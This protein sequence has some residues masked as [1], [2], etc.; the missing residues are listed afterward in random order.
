MN[1]FD[2]EERCSQIETLL[3]YPHVGPLTRAAIAVNLGVSEAA[4]QAPLQSLLQAS[5]IRYID[6][7][8]VTV[9]QR[10]AQPGVE[11]AGTACQ[12]GADVERGAA[13]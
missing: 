5:R 7:E 3:A 1:R 11:S 8:H 9:T 6:T 12:D 2:L 10:V 13:S 4:I